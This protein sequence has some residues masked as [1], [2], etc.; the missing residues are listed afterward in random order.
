MGEAFY[1]ASLWT[2]SGVTLGLFLLVTEGSFRLGRWRLHPGRAEEG[3]VGPTLGGLIGLLGLLLAFTFGMAGA[4][5]DQR[6]LL[7][8]DQ[9]NA[10]KTAFL[11]ADLLPD[12]QRGEAQ[13][14]LRQYLDVQLDAIS[15]AQTVAAVAASRPLLDKMWSLAVAAAAERPTVIS[16]LFV[17]S[18]NEVIS[19]QARRITLGWHNPLPPT[20]LGTLYFVALLVLGVMGFEGGL[21]GKHRPVASLVLGVTLAAV[22]LVIVDL[23]R[24]LEGLL[25][26]NL[27]PLI[28]LREQIARSAP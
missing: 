24:P 4:R 28:D 11:R 10:I 27:Q 1:R 5:F 15:P 14:L 20:I 13:T 6:R 22:V 25:R 3:Q 18:V 9:A 2:V 19:A 23:D 21:S 26:N 7:L 8:L 17:Q 12:A 16:S